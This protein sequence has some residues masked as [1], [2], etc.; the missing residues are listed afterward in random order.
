MKC[1]C[2]RFVGRFA[3]WAEHTD[4]KRV[5]KSEEYSIENM[6]VGMREMLRRVYWDNVDKGTF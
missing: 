4:T 1:A 2:S 5:V 3:I 6:A